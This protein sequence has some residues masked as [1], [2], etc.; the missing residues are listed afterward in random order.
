MDLR[1]FVC[2]VHQNNPTLGGT[3]YLIYGDRVLTARHVVEGKG[4]FEIRFD[5]PTKESVQSVPVRRVV[6]KGDGELDVAVLEVETGLRL[7]RQLFSCEAWSGERAF[8]SRGWAVGGHAAP[9]SGKQPVSAVLSGL[10]GQAYEFVSGA[11]TFEIEVEAPPEKVDDWAG[12][13][14]AAIFVDGY[15]V[16]IMPKGPKAFAGSRLRV[17]PIAVL[18]PDDEFRAAI[19]YD[20][21]IET[22]RV[23][24]RNELISDIK[25]LL[26]DI[27]AAGAIASAH[28]WGDEKS[29]L[30]LATALCSISSWRDALRGLEVAHVALS[31]KRPS[32]AKVVVEIVRR[33]LPE[34]YASTTQAFLRGA[35]GGQ[36]LTI[37]YESETLAELAMAALDGR[38][39]SFQPVTVPSHYPRGRASFDVE[40]EHQ[41]RRQGTQFDFS[42]NEVFREFLQTLA[43]WMNLDPQIQALGRKRDR[44]DSF[45]RAINAE[46]DDE[47]K[48][49]N[50][51]RRYFAFACEFA[52]EHAKLL[53]LLAQKLRALH[54]V[55][56]DAASLDEE[57][58]D[59]APLRAILFRDSQLKG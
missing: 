4:P 20:R 43:A 22:Q 35:T 9:P 5:D 32:S 56:L 1:R 11:A 53:D 7:P 39:L 40:A 37:P 23:K 27:D 58:S 36:L 13:S 29:N 51:P 10:R 49:R 50:E 54:L 59:L 42:G 25:A 2:I 46:L 41:K 18:W 12:A 14:G 17:V 47:V 34:I 21:D 31:S 26:E 33:V 8:R 38:P 24:R 3:G 30:E 6:W 57:T 48:S 44:L 16:G 55:Q 19:G 52:T 45:I 15:M 28:K